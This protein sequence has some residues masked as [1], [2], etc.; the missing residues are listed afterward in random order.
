MAE[1]T[2]RP[3]GRPRETDVRIAVGFPQDLLDELTAAAKAA[4]HSR[5]REIRIR[6]EKLRTDK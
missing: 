6:C 2:P 5:E 3:P 4:G 1:A